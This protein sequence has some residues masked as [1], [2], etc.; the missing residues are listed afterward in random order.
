MVMED[1]KGT[2]RK[3][4]MMTSSELNRTSALLR[5]RGF[6][7]ASHKVAVG[8]YDNQGLFDVLTPADASETYEDEMYEK[9]FKHDRGY[10]QNRRSHISFDPVVQFGT[11][12]RGCDLEEFLRSRALE[13]GESLKAEGFNVHAYEIEEDPKSA[14]RE[15]Y[16]MRSI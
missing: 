6:R 16:V 9:R 15:G 5:S 14:D 12:L 1:H 13:L 10:V 8:V 7:C 2:K 4:G 3:F 11:V